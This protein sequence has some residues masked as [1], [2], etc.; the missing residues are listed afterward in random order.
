MDDNTRAVL[1]S[2]LKDGYESYEKGFQKPLLAAF[3]C[4]EVAVAVAAESGADKPGPD[5]CCPKCAG[6]GVIRERRH[7]YDPSIGCTSQ[8]IYY[9]LTCT[10]CGGRGYLETWQMEKEEEPDG[11]QGPR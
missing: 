6:S 11:D 8:V 5:R 4:L 7:Y 9:T 1:L 2:A 10:R 3:A